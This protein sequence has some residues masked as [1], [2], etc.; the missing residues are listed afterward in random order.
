[1]AHVPN[2]IVLS[3]DRDLEGRDREL[4]VRRALFAVAPVVA[5]LALLNVF[6]QRPQDTSVTAPAATLRVHAPAR[7]RSGLLYEARF[8]IEAARRLRNAV[9]VLAPGWFEGMTV[10]TIE[11]SP[12]AERSVN[13]E[14]VLEL[15]AIAPGGSHVLYMS[16]QV[17]PTNVGRH[18][19]AV[20]LLDGRRPVL[21]MP[22][23]ITVFP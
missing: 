6:G 3:R 1:M 20:R 22:R 9:L 13:G 11:P 16:F 15:G 18:S 10:N 7:V 19:Q 17:N 4:W 12:E 14:T 21:A 23:T 2:E 8:T 5:V